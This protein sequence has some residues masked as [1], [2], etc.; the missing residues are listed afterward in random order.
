MRFFRRRPARRIVSPTVF[1][2][3]IRLICASL[4]VFC[5]P[6]FFATHGQPLANSML[7]WRFFAICMMPMLR[8]LVLTK[9]SLWQKYVQLL[10]L[11]NSTY[12][13][14]LAR[15]LQ[16]GSATDGQSLANSTLQSPVFLF[17]TTK[18]YSYY[19][20]W[21]PMHGWLYQFYLAHALAGIFDIQSS[22]GWKRIQ[23][24]LLPHAAHFA[25]CFALM[26]RD[27]MQ[28]GL[29]DFAWS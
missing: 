25:F 13:C 6:L 10:N 18:T 1:S 29:H 20:H 22:G 27:A 2:G 16:S 24:Q 21:R 11:L 8:M 12:L 19:N 26:F 14:K 23:V 5:N 4:H 28:P 17:S 7:Q 9:S 15:F 3:L